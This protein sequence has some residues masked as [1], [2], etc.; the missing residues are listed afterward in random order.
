MSRKLFEKIEGFIHGGDYNPEQWLDRPDI[1]R[2]D[3]RMMKKAE[4]NCVTLGVFSWSMYERKEG[5]FNFDWLENIIN[6]LYA[7]GIYT[8]LATPSGA[9]PVWIDKNYP[10]ALRVDERGI[11]LH[12]GMRHNHCN[13]SEN[14]REKVRII[15]TK[16]AERFAN[17]PAVLM[18]HISNEFGGFCYCD[19]C[20]R[21]FQQYLSKK[22]EGDID[23]LN[24][25][26]WTIFWSH[27]Y[28][29]FDEIEP[30]FDNGEHS[31]LGQKLE[32]RR[33]NTV[34][35]TDFMKMEIETLRR[36]NKDLPV[37]TNFMTLFEDYDYHYMAKELDIIS[38]DSYPFLHNDY[39]SLADTMCDNAFVHVLYRSMK[40]NQPFMLM[41]S[42][43]GLV[44]W[45]RFNKYKRP[46]V[47]KLFSMQALACGSDTV[48]YFQIRKGRGSFEQFH[49]AVIDHL[50]T[51]DTRV[52]KDVESLGKDLLKIKEVTGSI[53]KSSVA[54]IYDWENRWAIKE[55]AALSHESKEYDRTVMD[56]YK[57]LVSMGAE[58]DIVS[59]DADFKDYKVV[60]A[61]MLYLLKDNVGK[62]LKDFV[63][64]GGILLGTYF[65]GYVDK[66]TLTYLGGFPG[67]GLNKLFGIV[68]EEIDT[69]YP[70]DR[71]EIVFD[72]G[73]RLEIRD[74]AEYLRVSD[75]KVLAKYASDYVEGT[76][77]I[78]EN[79]VGKGKAYYIAARPVYLGMA[80]NGD[81]FSGFL[82]EVLCSAGI[83]CTMVPAGVEYHCRYT[84]EVK[85]QFFLNMTEEEKIVENI[86]GM[87]LFSDSEISGI[88]K[89]SPYQVMIVKVNVG[90]KNE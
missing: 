10:D 2:E 85:Y 51:D 55:S 39:E 45:T 37:T 25:A 44:N 71:N 9:K 79:Q 5:E 31:I 65:T 24:Q 30:C 40:K 63:E 7:N 90:G 33:F 32:W 83:D 57:R 61:P 80:D 89:L 46:G 12:H 78:T 59:S 21:K 22:F 56:F 60:I 41:E 64:E 87:E 54:L 49:G 50:G 77:A 82:K 86:N 88:L 70:K 67:Q 42:A 13:S 15:D 76:A 84:E 74:Y 20:K 36:Y 34:N 16:L 28:N 75:A 18:W 53:C 27:V 17:H 29:S 47:H 43:P 66:D 72:D 26:W 68:S 19:N 11:R 38:W 73:K 58:V 3:L 23:K 4:I 48:Q 52:F 81:V 69:L 14:Y 1:L 6:E 35:V 8:I 62:S